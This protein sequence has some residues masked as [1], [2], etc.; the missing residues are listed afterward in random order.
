M[1]DMVATV[2]TSVNNVRSQAVAARATDN[3]SPLWQH[4][5]MTE[6]LPNHLRAWRKYMRLSLDKVANATS[7]DKT[8][9]SRVERGERPLKMEF[10]REFAAAIGKAP[11]DLHKKPPAHR[12]LGEPELSTGKLTSVNPSSGDQYK[13]ASHTLRECDMKEDEVMLIQKYRQLGPQ[14]QAKILEA[15]EDQLVVKRHGERQKHEAPEKVG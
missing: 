3:L 9:L 8:W 1:P 12:E 6:S 5:G 7:V 10:F 4:L 11:Q 14:G 2:A 15:V 13:L